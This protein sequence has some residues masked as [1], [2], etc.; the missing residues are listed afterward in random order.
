MVEA[1]D[2]EGAEQL[3]ARAMDACLREARLAMGLA[4][5]GEMRAQRLLALEHRAGRRAAG[6]EAPFEIVGDAGGDLLDV[7]LVE[8]PAEAAEQVVDGIG[9]WFCSNEGQAPAP[10][11]SVRKV[12]ISALTTGSSKAASSWRFDVP[13]D[14][15][16]TTSLRPTSP[17]NCS[18]CFSASPLG[19]TVSVSDGPVSGSWSGTSEYSWLATWASC[20]LLFSSS[21]TKSSSGRIV[22]RHLTQKPCTKISLSR[23]ISPPR[24]SPI[25]GAILASSRG[26]NLPVRRREFFDQEVHEGRH[27]GGEMPAMRIDGMDGHRLVGREI[28]EQRDEG[29]LAHRLRKREAGQPHDADPLQGKLHLQLA[30]ADRDPAG[31]IDLGHLAV[32]LELPAVEIGPLA[33]HDADMA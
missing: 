32:D 9:H 15:A 10:T 4:L 14:L 31:D 7:G 18:V 20:P 27:L 12:R 1:G 30:I 6:I 16:T 28:A 2:A 13:S 21:T 23:S 5:V 29:A 26:S 25:L 24:H 33:R 22:S 8:G 17:R 19:C 11:T 3:V